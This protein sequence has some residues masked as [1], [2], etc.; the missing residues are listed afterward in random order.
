M[1]VHLLTSAY[2]FNRCK[3]CSWLYGWKFGSFRGA[4]NFA[5]A[6]ALFTERTP[7]RGLSPDILFRCA[8]SFSCSARI[9][10]LPDTARGLSV[11]F[12]SSDK[13][14]R[15]GGGSSPAIV[16]SG[17]EVLE[18]FAEGWVL[19]R[20]VMEVEAV[21]LSRS[22]WNLR[23]VVARAGVEGELDAMLAIENAGWGC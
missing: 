19:V 10:S 22:L 7:A 11:A 2:V 14:E 17:K 8:K 18:A 15:L 5:A 23:F 4:D 21:R 6:S 13:R 12:P 16:D 9:L 3:N 20:E 1:F